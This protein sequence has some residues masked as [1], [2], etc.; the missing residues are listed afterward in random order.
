MGWVLAGRVGSPAEPH[1]L[2]VLA[3]RYEALGKTMQLSRASV[4]RVQLLP[5]GSLNALL[6]LMAMACDAARLTNPRAGMHVPVDVTRSPEARHLVFERLPEAQ[7]VLIVRGVRADWDVP[8]RLLGRLT[9]MSGMSA[10]LARQQLAAS[11]VDSDDPLRFTR[12]RLREVL[13]K[14][15]ARPPALDDEELALGGSV[16]DDAALCVALGAWW[17]HEQIPSPWKES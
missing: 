14:A 6:D 12:D 9:L 10:L 7:P 13:G 2:A 1:V 3:T 4:Q 15:Q 11:I 8:Y 5:G 17:A 16:D